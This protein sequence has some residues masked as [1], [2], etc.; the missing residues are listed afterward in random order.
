ML[1]T[2]EALQVNRF[3][4]RFT[5]TYLEVKAKMKVLPYYRYFRITLLLNCSELG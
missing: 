2:K 1:P 4:N 5:D 3:F